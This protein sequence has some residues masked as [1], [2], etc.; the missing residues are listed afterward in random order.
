MTRFA[1]W[2]QFGAVHAACKVDLGIT[3]QFPPVDARLRQGQLLSRRGSR[4]SARTA[5]PSIT[6]ATLR[7]HSRGLRLVNHGRAGRWASRLESDPT[8]TRDCGT[9]VSVSLG[10]RSGQDTADGLAP[11]LVANFRTRCHPALL[12]RGS[13]VRAAAGRRRPCVPSP[14]VAPRQRGL[15]DADPRSTM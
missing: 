1:E 4:Q 12:R 7:G 10:S 15:G 11:D 9:S 6:F 8:Q 13:S 3:G 5:P 2:S 14:P